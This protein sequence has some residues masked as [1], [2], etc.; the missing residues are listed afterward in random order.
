MFRFITVL[1][2]IL[3][4][5]IANSSLLAVE[6]IFF[7]S[8]RAVSPSYANNHIWMINPEDVDES[9]LEQLTFGDNFDE[10]PRLSPDGRTIVFTRFE[11]NLVCS[12]LWTLDLITRQETQI[13]GVGATPGTRTEFN[14]TWNSTGDNIIYNKNTSGACSSQNNELWEIEVANTAN[15]VKL[16]NLLNRTRPYAHPNGVDIFYRNDTAS[17]QRIFTFPGDVDL[18]PDDNKDESN[19]MVSYDGSRIA[20]TSNDF[21]LY[22]ADL[23][24]SVVPSII[25]GSQTEFS[26]ISSNFPGYRHPAWSP[27]GDKLVFNYLTSGFNYDLYTADV[28]DFAN[29]TLLLD[30]ANTRYVEPFWG[31]VNLEQT[32]NAEKDSFLR[33]GNSNRNEGANPRLVV[34]AT[35]SNRAVMS[36]DLSSLDTQN[37]TSAKLILTVAENHSNWGSEGRPVD[38]YPLLEEFEEGNG[39]RLGVPSSESTRGTGQ[40]ITWKCAV[41]E[42]ISNKKPDCA[43]EWDGAEAGALGAMSDSVIHTND[44]QSYDEIEW[45]VTLD[46]QNGHAS[47]LLKKPNSMTG[48]V[49]YYSREGADEEGD[50]SLAPRL[51]LNF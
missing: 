38:A 39:K 27:N 20:F 31:D 33:S 4:L 5:F 25:P 42:D 6:K 8:N 45:D 15:D 10:A 21:T 16:T 7:S 3:S 11:S 48:R 32:A 44:L 2:L 50:P 40:G 19:P 14:P 35:G 49:N 24:V 41:D 9:T 23:D 43:N 1:T 36:F 46:V 30:T 17:P 29:R 26:P 18:N 22:I 28:D 13:T 47:W 34:R 37:V 12:H 51:I